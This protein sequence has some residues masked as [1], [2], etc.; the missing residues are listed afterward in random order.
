MT[1]DKPDSRVT[2]LEAEV[3]DLREQVDALRRQLHQ[4]ST[5][6]ADAVM[7]SP[8]REFRDEKEMAA[9]RG[10]SA[11]AEECASFADLNFADL[12]TADDLV[13]KNA[14]FN[15][16]VL[17]TTTDCIKILGLDGRLEFMNA[18]GQRVM[19][20]EDFSRLSGCPWTEFWQGDERGKASDAVETAK[21]GRTA[22]FEGPANT[23]KG[24][25]RY[26]EVTV[27]PILGPGGKPE[28]LLSISRDITDRHAAE[29]H[30]RM[31]FDEMHHR[32]KNT[33]ATVQGITHQSM[34]HSTDMT[35]AELS[36]SQR[37]TALGKAHDLLILNEWI[38]ADILDVVTDAV[39]A[40]IGDGARM[41]VDGPSIN[42][43][44]KAALTIAMLLNELC[45]NAFK[46]GAWSNRSGFVDIS[47]QVTGS[48]FSFRWAE[49]GGPAVK[50]PSRRSFGSRLIEKLMPAALDGRATLSFDLRG[51]VFELQAPARA[52][53][54]QTPIKVLA[55]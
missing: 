38:N 8:H 21:A 53:S 5:D 20:V 47:W 6:A 9:A 4:Q 33:L 18:G 11:A 46:H 37:L 49:R 7:A 45:T 36:I 54:D 25:P 50:P 42:L 27:S 32:I 39:A 52:L 34:R 13:V 10:R 3:V 19:E 26:W 23:A 28:K 44:S 16:L 31:L 24:N 29:L 51:V 43:S 15:R 2:A 48:T 22:R 14:D 41:T 30:L 1:E 55:E 17:E 40:Y 35:E 12:Q